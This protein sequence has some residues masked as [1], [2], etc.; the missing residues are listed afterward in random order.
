[1]RRD[2]RASP[3]RRRTTQCNANVKRCKADGRGRPA[4][5]RAGLADLNEPTRPAPHPP[6]TSPVSLIAPPREAAPAPSCPGSDLL[7]RYRA[8]RAQTERLGEPLEPE[9]FVVQSMPDASPAKWHLAHTS[10]FFETFVL[11]AAL[12]DY[13]PRLSP[14]QL[15]VQFL[16]Q[17]DRRADR[18][19]PPGAALAADGRRGLPL[20][21]ARSTRLMEAGSDRPIDDDARA[22]G[23]V[24]VLGLHH[25][26]Q[27][28]EL[29]LTDLKH[30]FARNPLRPAYRERTRPTSGAAA[31]LALGRLPGGVAPDRPRG[32]GLRLRQRVAPAPRVPRAFGL[33]SR[34]VDQRR[35]PR[36]HRRRRLRPPR[37]LALRR[38]GRPEVA[39]LD[40]PALLGTGR[41]PAG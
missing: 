4:R 14:I 11:T 29:I 33:A 37:V 21:V 22:A 30:V 32:A 38:L 35:V 9:D 25:E 40:R 12:P 36:V 41:R 5:R 10:W 2:G 28:Q 6:R 24:V 8:V 1:M 26:Q 19:R 3:A 13:R 17:R 16:L 15:P 39:G 34:L 23:P 7:A 27:H 31:P 18:P 20:P